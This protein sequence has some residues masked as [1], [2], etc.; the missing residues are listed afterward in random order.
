M[1]IDIL[2]I[3][4]SL[5]K[6]AFTSL[7]GGWP[8]FILAAGLGWLAFISEKPKGQAKTAAGWVLV[9]LGFILFVWT[10]KG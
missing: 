2:E 10:L 6:I 3:I 9:L 7:Q 4:H 1:E 8:L 5:P